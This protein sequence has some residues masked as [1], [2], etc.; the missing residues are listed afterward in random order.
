MI[1][2]SR[3]FLVETEDGAAEYSG[4]QDNGKLFTKAKDDVGYGDYQKHRFW[5]KKRNW[6]L[7]EIFGRT[8]PWTDYQWNMS[9]ML[10]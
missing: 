3:H 8:E 1:A 6:G 5:G 10:I 9:L 4:K 7:N 2:T